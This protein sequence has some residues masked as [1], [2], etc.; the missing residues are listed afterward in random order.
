MNLRRK[1]SVSTVRGVS[2]GLGLLVC[3]CC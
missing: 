1:I 3:H 2:D